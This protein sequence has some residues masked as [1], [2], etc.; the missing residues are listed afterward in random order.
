MANTNRC[1]RQ[2]LVAGTL[3]REDYP[4]DGPL[5]EDFTLPSQTAVFQVTIPNGIF[6]AGIGAV[7][8]GVFKTR[9]NYK[10]SQRRGD[11]QDV[12]NT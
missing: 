12:V 8:L 4:T 10:F 9:V 3:V 7:V 2:S 1:W 6:A 5:A 11:I